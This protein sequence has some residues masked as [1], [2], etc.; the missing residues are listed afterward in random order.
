M[1]F[2]RKCARE[3]VLC[4]RKVLLCAREVLFYVFLPPFSYSEAHIFCPFSPAVGQILGV[5]PPF[6]RVCGMCPT[7]RRRFPEKS[8]EHGR[9]RAYLCIVNQS[10][11]SQ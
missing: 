1:E 6:V 8:L 10:E 4:A 2:F 11:R 3:A 7:D 5:F 9:K